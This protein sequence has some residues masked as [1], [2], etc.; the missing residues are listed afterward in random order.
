MSLSEFSH[1]PPAPSPPATGRRVALFGEAL[2]DIFPHQRVWGG[3]PL[4]VARHLHRF[5]AQ[6]L[7]VTCL[8]SDDLGD[9]LFQAIAESGMATSA[10]QRSDRYP[11]G[12]V[13]IDLA[14][15]AHRFTIPGEQAY[16]HI[17]GHLATAVTG[18]FQPR[19]VY[20]GTLAQRCAASRDAL[21]E[22]LSL[23]PALTFCD[24]NLRSPWY[25]KDTLEHS[26]QRTDIL[27]L[28]HEE[29]DLLAE[30]FTLAAD[31][32]EDQ[33][34]RLMDDFG[35]QQIVL[36]R[37]EEGAW[38]LTADG[39]LTKVDSPPL[40]TP[41]VDT[42]GA[43]DAFCAVYILGILEGWPPSQTLA[44]ANHFAAAV[45]GIRGAL[46]ADDELHEQYRR[47]WTP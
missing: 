2:A 34:A 16:D 38:L 47:L 41:L 20:F 14:D 18:P 8:G 17:D 33:L 13:E 44:R 24:I 6:P 28:N 5:G 25:R 22:I 26:L 37:G 46:P 3:A 42:V 12:R 23:C 4:N 10:I 9:E 19:V 36:T 7:F 40:A 39:H 45:C 29:L 31:H 35:L 32:P 21:G 43:G 15:G 11:T 1:N 30:M 27:K